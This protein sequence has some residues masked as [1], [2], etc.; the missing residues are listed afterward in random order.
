LSEP[1]R[2]KTGLQQEKLA[3]KAIIHIFNL[4]FNVQ[5]LYETVTADLFVSDANMT[6]MCELSTVSH[7]V[8]ACRLLLVWG[9]CFSASEYGLVAVLF[10]VN[11][12][13]PVVVN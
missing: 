2:K 12:Q 6:V 10:Y 8:P 4:I 5:N 9:V 7:L 3:V 1:F 11:M 13:I